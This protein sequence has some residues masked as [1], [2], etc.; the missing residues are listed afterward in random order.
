MITELQAVKNVPGFYPNLVIQ[1]LFE[2]A[3]RAGK[4]RGGNAAGIEAEGPLSSTKLF[5]T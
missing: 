4:E 2:G 5:F 1:P 3:I